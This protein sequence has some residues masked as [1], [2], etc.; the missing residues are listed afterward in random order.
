MSSG[1]FRP[2]LTDAIRYWEPRRLLYNVALAS[3]VIG[4]FFLQLPHSQAALSLDLGLSLFILA[5]LANVA[6][7]AV[8]VPDLAM[9]ISGYRDTWL[10]NRWLL[11]LLG[12][13]FAC[14]IAN[15]VAR[16]ML[17]NAP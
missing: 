6:F 12:T 8:Y 14:A 13:A 4:H 1:N 2:L 17:G 16:S 3:V 9:Q 10:K 11:L 7:S 15:F 5:V